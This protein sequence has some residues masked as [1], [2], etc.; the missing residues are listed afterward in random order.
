MTSAADLAILRKVLEFVPSQISESTTHTT[1]AA[2]CESLGL[3]TPPDEGTK[4]Q[5]A[6]AS[7]DALPDVGLPRVAEAV[8]AT[9][10][11]GARERNTVEDA[12]WAIGEDVS[13][14][15]RVRRGIARALDLADLVHDVGRFGGLLDRVWVLDD[16]PISAFVGGGRSLRERVD[17][18]VYRNPGDWTTEEL[19]DH[20][21]AFDAPNKRFAVFLEGLASA[22]VVPDEHA[23]RAFVDTVN[24]HLH[25]VGAELRETGEDGGYPVFSIV[26]LRSTRGRPKNLIFASP[27]KPDIRFS[28]AIDNDIEIVSNADKVL[29]YDLPVGP[30]GLRWRDLQTWWKQTR[31]FDSDGEAKDTLYKRLRDSLPRNSPPQHTLF[32]L[33]HRVHGAQVPDLPAL[34]P[35]V[36][37]HWDPQTVRMRGKNALLNFRMDFLLLL[38]HG[39]RVVLEVDGTHHYS[40]DGRADPIV[41]ARTVRGD[42]DLTLS[43]YEVF[44]FG[45][46][47]LDN[48]QRAR[49]VVEQFFH[50]LYRSLR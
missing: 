4:H 9:G 37:L 27:E 48:P 12:L 39:R 6:S 44:R 30:G 45:A 10:A 23:Q 17:R 16:D 20:L 38:P 7:F 18:H 31:N 42:R 14:L 40:T 1:L 32:D 25:Q 3:P 33:Y 47:E 15:K 34:L 5:R 43:G 2:A 50:D 28:D 13:I 35:E 49:T 24:R 8:L 11:L 41:Y 19:F 22:D 21:G 26:S 36:W 29:V 46:A